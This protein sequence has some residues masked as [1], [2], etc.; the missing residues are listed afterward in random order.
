MYALW[1]VQELLL[2][3]YLRNLVVECY[4]EHAEHGFGGETIPG[5]SKHNV[6]YNS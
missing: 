2:S 1:R 5:Q 3:L 4:P 6:L